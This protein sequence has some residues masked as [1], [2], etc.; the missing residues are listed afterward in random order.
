MVLASIGSNIKVETAFSELLV[1][2]Q[3]SN[4]LFPDEVGLFFF[5]E[6]CAVIFAADQARMMQ[7]DAK[8]GIKC[9][10][11]DCFQFPWFDTLQPGHLTGLDFFLA[12]DTPP[13]RGR[14]APDC[15]LKAGNPWGGGSDKRTLAKPSFPS[16]LEAPEKT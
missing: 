14:E 4:P 9:C 8:R 11:K 10:H 2:R 1:D 13:R 12:F 7:N 16:P 5:A 6:I 3:C 15:F